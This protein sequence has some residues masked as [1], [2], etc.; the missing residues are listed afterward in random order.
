VANR[1]RGWAVFVHGCF[2]HAHAGCPRATLPKRN[3][4]FWVDKLAANRRRDERSLRDLRQLGYRTLV[5]WE[6]ETGRR[7]PSLL[8]RFA[9]RLHPVS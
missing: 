5:V 6:C 8:R 1:R 9:R 4:Q 3:R 7:L 2:W